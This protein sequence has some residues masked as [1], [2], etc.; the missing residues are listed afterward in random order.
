[1]TIWATPLDEGFAMVVV[2]ITGAVPVTEIDTAL[3]ITTRVLVGG[4]FETVL[5][6]MTV[7]PLV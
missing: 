3:L 1:M 2:T 7:A 5:V 4:G 6:T